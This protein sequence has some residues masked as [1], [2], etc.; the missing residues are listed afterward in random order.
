MED[1]VEAEATNID[2]DLSNGK[3]VIYLAEGDAIVCKYSE[4]ITTR[5]GSSTWYTYGVA[6][7]LRPDEIEGVEL[8][9]DDEV[10]TVLD[11]ASTRVISAALQGLVGMRRANAYMK[12]QQK[13][14]LL[15]QQRG[16]SSE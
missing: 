15:E 4:E 9:D 5:P 10:A 3:Y 1:V 14:L 8:D 6:S 13:Q 2:D 16:A 12:Q 11:M 7:A